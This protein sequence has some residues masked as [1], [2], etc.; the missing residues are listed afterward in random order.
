MARCRFI[1]R[2]A[3]C[4]KSRKCKMVGRGKHRRKLACPK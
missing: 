1:K 3:K 2:D 4:G